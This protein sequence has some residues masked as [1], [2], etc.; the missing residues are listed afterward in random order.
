MKYKLRAARRWIQVTL[1]GYLLAATAAAFGLYALY[2]Y[3]AGMLNT[4]LAA[5]VTAGG[6]LVLAGLIVLGGF[7]C[8]MVHR[9]R[10]GATRTPPSSALWRCG[11]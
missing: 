11:W 8:R 7:I 9:P 4:L 3:A 10:G 6:A 1:A 2:I 5:V